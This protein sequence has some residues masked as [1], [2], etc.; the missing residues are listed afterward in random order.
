MSGEDS[1]DIYLGLY[2][3]P[4]DDSSEFLWSESLSNG[5]FAIVIRE[6]FSGRQGVISN[7]VNWSRVTLN[8]IPAHAGIQQPYCSI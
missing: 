6:T 4:V 1:C 3:R 8:V 5:G 7:S 2:M